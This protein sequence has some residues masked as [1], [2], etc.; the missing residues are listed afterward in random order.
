MDNRTIN[1][2]KRLH[3]EADRTIELTCYTWD[4]TQNYNIKGKSLHAVAERV[5][6]LCKIIE[7][8]LI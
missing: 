7:Q 8:E 1:K 6:W 4:K 3:K 5:K 2:V